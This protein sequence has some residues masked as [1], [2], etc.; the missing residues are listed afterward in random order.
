MY[1][2]THVVARDGYFGMITGYAIMVIKINL[3]RYE[4]CSRKFISSVRV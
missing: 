4:K 2:V 3:T 1:G